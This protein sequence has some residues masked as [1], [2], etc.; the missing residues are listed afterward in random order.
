MGRCGQIPLVFR[1][2]DHATCLCVA[3]RTVL[4]VRLLPED[5]DDRKSESGPPIDEVAIELGSLLSLLVREPLIPLGP[6]RIDGRPIRFDQVNRQVPRS[7]PASK[8]P[9]CGVNSVELRAILV[10]LSRAKEGDANAIL[11]ASRLYHAA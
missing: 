1:R 10:G 3:P 11:A 4:I 5:S 7:P 2:S 9:A 6:R 8:V